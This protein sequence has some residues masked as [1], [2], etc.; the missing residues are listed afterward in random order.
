MRGLRA[1]PLLFTTNY[2]ICVQN[3]S[4]VAGLAQMRGSSTWDTT[5]VSFDSCTNRHRSSLPR[6][7]PMCSVSFPAR[8]SVKSRLAVRMPFIAPCSLQI[9]PSRSCPVGG[10]ANIS[11]DESACMKAHTRSPVS[12]RRSNHAAYSNSP[13]T[14]SGD[15]VGANT[16]SLTVVAK[17]FN[18]H[19]DLT[20]LPFIRRAQPVSRIDL[21]GGISVSLTQEYSCR[22]FICLVSRSSP[23]LT[24]LAGN[25]SVDQGAFIARSNNRS[26]FGQ[27]S[28]LTSNLI[29]SSPR[30]WRTFLAT[31]AFFDTFS[32]STGSSWWEVAGP[33]RKLSSS[34]G[35]A[36]FP[37]CVTE[38]DFDLFGLGPVELELGSSG[39]VSGS[40]TIPRFASSADAVRRLSSQASW[41]VLHS[42]VCDFPGP[43]VSHVRHPG[44]LPISDQKALILSAFA[45][46]PCPRI[47]CTCSSGGG[48]GGGTVG[49]SSRAVT[50]GISSSGREVKGGPDTPES[51]SIS[52]F[53]FVPRA[54]TVSR[55]LHCSLVGFL[56]TDLHLSKP[57]FVP[58]RCSSDDASRPHQQPLIHLFV[59]LAARTS[60]SGINANTDSP[61][62]H[63]GDT[64]G[65]PSK[66][67]NWVLP[68]GRTVNLESTN[69]A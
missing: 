6:L 41:Y 10:R 62:M 36:K 28:S 44:V 7:K 38:V 34:I 61:N 65:V 54:S 43:G 29:L 63:K 22:S 57:C 32:S 5:R 68:S 1:S 66:Y 13:S 58:T 42:R 50:V 11:Q 39:R 67:W 46:T 49:I 12:T 45:C 21:S 51:I 15:G 9:H 16:S 23:A 56:R 47:S 64:Y 37:L 8:N 35:S 19:R 3:F 4:S 55:R 2:V 59:S 52:K 48:A 40:P 31:R 14:D 69:P 53:H 33:L 17:S 24:L 25:Q 60:W 26:A 20:W 18:T 30:M 27:A